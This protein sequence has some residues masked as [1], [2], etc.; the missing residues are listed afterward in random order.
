MF[1]LPGMR[2]HGRACKHDMHVTWIH[3]GQGALLAL[4]SDSLSPLGSVRV[5]SL[6]A[7]CCCILLPLCFPLSSALP[8]APP[9]RHLGDG[10][11]RE[12]ARRAAKQA[13]S[14]DRLRTVLLQQPAPQAQGM[15]T[16]TG[17][18]EATPARATRLAQYWFRHACAAR[19]FYEHRHRGWVPK[20]GGPTVDQSTAAVRF[21]SLRG[22]MHAGSLPSRA[23]ALQL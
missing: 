21:C 20:L 7:A 8:S 17:G 13:H 10:H 23:P 3:G 18:R 14:T 4:T 6:T 15:Q 22:C 5:H 11:H 2:V 16:G 9:C 12:A 1:V 19:T